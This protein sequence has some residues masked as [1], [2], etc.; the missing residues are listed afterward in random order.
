MAVEVARMLENGNNNNTNMET[1]VST[2]ALSYAIM[3]TNNIL[4]D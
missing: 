1:F 4:P 3:L 2:N